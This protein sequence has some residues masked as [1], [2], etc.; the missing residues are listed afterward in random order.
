LGGGEQSTILL[1]SGSERIPVSDS[2]GM[3]G[4]GGVDERAVR[5]SGGVV[6]G[7]A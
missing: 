5:A 2:W 6:P 3:H 1:P 4:G 7:G